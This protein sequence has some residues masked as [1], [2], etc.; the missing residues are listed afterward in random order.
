MTN[1]VK[2]SPRSNKAKAVPNGY[3]V[4]T[5]YLTVDGVAEAIEFYRKAFGA[6]ERLRVPGFDGKVGHAEIVINGHAIMLTDEFFYLEAKSPRA[7]G[8]TT[9]GIHLYV[10]DMDAVVEQALAAGCRIVFPIEDQFCGN[11]SCGLADP[12][13]H[14]WYVATH[15]EDMSNEEMYRRAHEAIKAHESLKKSAA[16]S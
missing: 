1:Q 16:K 9:S 10:E 11:R 14:N 13:G 6:E 3:H 7:L 5:P 2:P 8:G 12:F 4:I 15:I